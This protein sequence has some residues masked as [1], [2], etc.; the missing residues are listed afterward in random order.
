MKKSKSR[1]G[2][3]DGLR[4]IAAILGAISCPLLSIALARPVLKLYDEPTY[5]WLAG[6]KA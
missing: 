6:R 2:I 5:R 1:Y 3:L 4:G